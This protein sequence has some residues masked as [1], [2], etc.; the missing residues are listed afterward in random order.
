M[1]TNFINPL[2]NLMEILPSCRRAFSRLYATLATLACMRMH[3]HNHARNKRAQ[4]C[5]S[6]M[7][8]IVTAAMCL[9]SGLYLPSTTVACRFTNSAP[10]GLG[11]LSRP[12]GE[13]GSDDCEAC[14]RDSSTA[15]SQDANESC[16]AQC[17]WW[18]GIPSTSAVSATALA[19]GALPRRQR[20]RAASRG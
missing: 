8:C 16:A 18:L 6:T 9:R 14:G 20:P 17:R 19:C 11:C 2:G 1:I 3:R 15:D 5:T 4:T 13:R 7:R 12:L 10:R